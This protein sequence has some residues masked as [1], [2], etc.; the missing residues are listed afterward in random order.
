MKTIN[1][2][3]IKQQINK[4][5]LEYDPTFPM[6][7]AQP[8]LMNGFK[9]FLERTA[10]V[11]LEFEPEVNNKGQVGYGVKRVEI[12]DDKKYMMWLIKYSS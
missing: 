2:H 3:L 10:G 5:Y 7:Y 4:C 1:S 9:Y 8:N 11:R 12:L 6:G